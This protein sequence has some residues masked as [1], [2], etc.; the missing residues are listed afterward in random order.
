MPLAVYGHMVDGLGSE[1]VKIL[2][3]LVTIKLHTNCTRLRQLSQ[4]AI[5]NDEFFMNPLDNR[6]VSE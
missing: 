2:D 4:N 6:K 5:V 1:A 3:N